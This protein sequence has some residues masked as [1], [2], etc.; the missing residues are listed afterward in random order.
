MNNRLMLI[1]MPQYAEMSKEALSLTR[2]RSGLLK[3][4][5]FLRCIVQ[6]LNQ[7]RSDHI[8]TAR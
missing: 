8:P 3:I 4:R 6:D 1:E 7:T 2:I 5:A